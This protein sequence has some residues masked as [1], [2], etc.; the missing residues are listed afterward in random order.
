MKRRMPIIIKQAGVIKNT[1]KAGKIIV[2]TAILAGY[3]TYINKK[4]KVDPNKINMET[5]KQR[6]P[7]DGYRHWR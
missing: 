1:Y 5:W 6:R 3:L 7:V 2:P 4:T